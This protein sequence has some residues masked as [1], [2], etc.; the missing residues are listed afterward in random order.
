MSAGS[1]GREQFDRDLLERF[2]PELRYDRQYD[3]RAAAVETI[4]NQ[5][6]ILRRFDGEVVARGGGEPALTLGLLTDYPDELAPRGDDCL[7]E[8]PD[9]LGDARRMERQERFGPRVYGRVV[10]EDGLTW[11]QYWF[12]LYYNPKNLFGF[13]KHEGDWEMVQIAL[14]PGP[15]P[16]LATYA[17]HDSGE[18][19]VVDGREVEF[20]TRGDEM[21]P[22]V[23]VA[24]LSH[25]SY[26]EAGTHPYPVGID[27]PYGDGPRACPPVEELGP[28]AHWEGRWGSSERVIARRVG[29]G[30][31]SPAHQRSKWRS[32]GGFHRSM[33][34]RRLRVLLGRALHAL[35]A[36]TYPPAPEIEVRLE[37]G[38]VHVEYRLGGSGPRRARSPYLT[39][40]DGDEVLASRV[41]R[42]AGRAGRETILLPERPERCVVWASA[43]NRIRQRS[44]LARAEASLAGGR[45][46]AGRAEVSD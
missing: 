31:P 45:I 1:P 27:H 5:G 7:S 21:H 15:R 30:P 13:G 32:P 12:W 35:G 29:K 28:W 6:N 40:H 8:A 43:F 22:V 44:D 17:Q 19:R 36:L 20:V 38:A 9:H 24:P 37:L 10:A 42:E 3:Y 23:Y 46:P 11:L 14:G 2:R 26:F 18:A 4:E 39:A 33:R 41:V 34:R 16:L 25:A